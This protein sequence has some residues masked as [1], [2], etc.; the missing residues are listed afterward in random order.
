DRNVLWAAGSEEKKDKIMTHII[1]M[2]KD[3]G[4]K[5]VV[6]GVENEEQREKLMKLEVEYLQGFLYSLPVSRESFFA[7]ISDAQN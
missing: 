4:F 7:M 5:V 6:E 1:Q 3:L 2:I